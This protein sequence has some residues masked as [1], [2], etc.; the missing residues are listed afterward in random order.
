MNVLFGSSI[1]ALTRG[2][3]FANQRHEVLAQNLA[4]V[5][6]PN[7][8]ARDLVRDEPLDTTSDTPAPLPR[9]TYSGDGASGIGG[10]D[11]DL[12]R[13]MG[14]IAENTLLHHTRVQLL[15]SQFASLK[16]AISGRV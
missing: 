16:Q 4:N 8:R 15:A 10:N 14:R 5:E 11:V 12:E 13:E 7:Y 6:T 1:T 9:V 2:L 3:T